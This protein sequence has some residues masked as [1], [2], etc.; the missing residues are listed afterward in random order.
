M[1]HE[2]RSPTSVSA[3]KWLSFLI[4]SNADVESCV[5]LRA[6]AGK[7]FSKQQREHVLIVK[8][9]CHTELPPFVYIIWCPGNTIVDQG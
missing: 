7:R 3:R 9:S 2:L 5:T 4:G 6:V 8:D 1:S